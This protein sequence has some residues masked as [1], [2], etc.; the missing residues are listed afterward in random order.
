[1]LAQYYPSTDYSGAVWKRIDPQVNFNLAASPGGLVSADFSVKRT[2]R[3]Q[4]Y[5]T[6]TYKFEVVST[7][8]DIERGMITKNYAPVVPSDAGTESEDSLATKGF[9]VTIVPDADKKL[10]YAW[11]GTPA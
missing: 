8:G 4:A 1:M 7:S 3:V 10:Y 2:G 5:F 6:E 9:T 11:K